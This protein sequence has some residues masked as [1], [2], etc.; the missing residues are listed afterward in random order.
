MV[1]QMFEE[2]PLVDQETMNRAIK[3]LKENP[4]VLDEAR[5]GG[6]TNAMVRDFWI[7]YGSNIDYTPEETARAHYGSTV[8][9]EQF[10]TYINDV[11]VQHGFTE[12][13]V[14]NLDW[15]S[16]HTLDFYCEIKYEI[17]HLLDTDVPVVF[18]MYSDYDSMNSYY[19][20]T[21]GLSA[22]LVVKDTY[23]GDVLNVLKIDPYKLSH[24]INVEHDGLSLASEESYVDEKLFAEELKNQ[25]SSDAL[26]MICTKVPFRKL[27]ERKW[28][29]LKGTKIGFY[30]ES[31]GGGS[32]FDCELKR[33]LEVEVPWSKAK[34]W[35]FWGMKP[36]CYMNYSM[37]K[38]Y[39][40]L[41][42]FD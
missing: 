18:A 8:G 15:E 9:L 14:L 23:L 30:S 40:N 4:L 26:L 25:S 38:C 5:L 29:I 12:E 21:N 24:F 36:E 13:D 34:D 1:T 31:E 41:S 37:S 16:G 11:L 20:E 2:G 28:T 6:L 17:E 7:V 39:G 22:P 35:P 10:L 42:M 19:F 32:T 33:D 27:N 3:I